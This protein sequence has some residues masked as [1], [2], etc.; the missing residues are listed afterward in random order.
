M[1][2]FPSVTV[3]LDARAPCTEKTGLAVLVPSRSLGEVLVHL[4]ASTADGSTVHLRCEASIEM[5]GK[6]SSG[7]RKRHECEAILVPFN[8]VTGCLASTVLR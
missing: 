5:Q 7:L 1:K 3:G 4:L 8:G 2:T 6:V